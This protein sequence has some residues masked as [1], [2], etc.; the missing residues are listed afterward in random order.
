MTYWRLTNRKRKP[1][2]VH[3]NSGVSDHKNS[4]SDLGETSPKKKLRLVHLIEPFC[5]GW[6][7]QTV[8]VYWLADRL[9]FGRR[10]NPHGQSY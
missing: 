7:P 9:Y 10:P 1:R 8:N 4:K 6:G 3:D 2:Y 5:K